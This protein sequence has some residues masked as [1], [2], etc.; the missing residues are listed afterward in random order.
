MDRRKLMQTIGGLGIAS[1]LGLGATGTAAADDHGN[2]NGSSNGNGNGNG[3]SSGTGAG[4][5]PYGG[6]STKTAP[7]LGTFDHA[8]M[9]LAEGIV[10]GPT[11]SPYA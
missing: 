11:E 8:L 7:E 5:T 3:G 10:D 2:G 9:Y 6:R 1:T 4:Y